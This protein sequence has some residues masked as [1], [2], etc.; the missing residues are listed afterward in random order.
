MRTMPDNEC[1]LDLMIPDNICESIRTHKIYISGPDLLL[2][3]VDNPVGHMSKR[4]NNPVL[5]GEVIDL[6]LESSLFFS[7]PGQAVNDLR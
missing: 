1:T 6:L 5:E 3:Q 2:M 7:S 4:S